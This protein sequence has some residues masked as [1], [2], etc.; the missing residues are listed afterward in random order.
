[1]TYVG[2]PSDLSRPPAAKPFGNAYGS[3]ARYQ[4]SGSVVRGTVLQAFQG[5]QIYDVATDFGRVQAFYLGA[6][7]GRLGANESAGF[8]PGSQ[9]WV[10]YSP[11]APVF[12]AVILGAATY[13]RAGDYKAP[14]PLLVYP[15]VSGF[16]PGTRSSGQ[17]FE[18]FRKLRN[19]NSG[20]LDTVNGDWIMHNT[21]GGALGVEI[22]R[23]FI[24]GGPMS[25][26]Y[27]YTEDNRTRIVGGTYE[28]MTFA[29][30][31]EDR[32]QGPGLVQLGRQV[33]YPM[34]AIYDNVPQRLQVAGPVYGGHQEFHSYR[35][36]NNATE[37]P[38]ADRISLLHEYRG[39]DGAYV[40]TSANSITLQRQVGVRVPLEII[41]P[42]GGDEVADPATCDT[43]CGLAADLPEKPLDS[44]ATN[45]AILQDMRLTMPDG[46]NPVAFA[47]NARGMADRLIHWQARGGFD[48]LTEQWTQGEKPEFVYQGK[49]NPDLTFTNSSGMWK[50]VPQ[51]FEVVVEPYG[52]TKNMYFGRS[53]ISITSDGSIVLQDAQGSQIMMSG[54]NIYLSAPHDVITV[55]GRNN[56]MMSG[57]DTAVRSSRHV[58]INAN[59][60][61]F[62]A[63]SSGQATLAGG[64]DGVSGV[65]IESFGQYNAAT[66]GEQPATAGGVNIR[67]NH[68]VGITAADIHLRAQGPQGWSSVSGG[69]GVISL[70]AGEQVN[71]RANNRAFYGCFGN[72]VSGKVAG[73]SFSIGQTAVFERL[74][75]TESLF[76]K[77]LYALADGAEVGYEYLLEDMLTPLG[78]Y[79]DNALESETSPLNMGGSFTIKW[80]SS[81]QYNLHSSVDFSIPEPE[82]QNRARDLNEGITTGDAPI[83][84]G[85][86][87]Q[88]QDLSGTAPLPGKTS[89]A[90]YGMASLPYDTPDYGDEGTE[91]TWTVSYLP[92]EGNLLKGI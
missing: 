15:Q 58:D 76:Y 6:S 70:D 91:L 53:I 56:L 68:Q 10:A 78:T 8:L 48:Q 87:F 73:G 80:L 12:N 43:G 5:L 51:M 69:A 57:R 60:G 11:A 28:L 2:L 75:T 25:G 14:S 83:I 82:W 27:C 46:V 20:I 1:M 71:W 62:Q 64:R 16:E 89:W 35:A 36:K 17:A 86:T 79:L 44:G 74:A 55:A 21:F 84:L 66:A 23:S 61:H 13:V 54:G 45:A 88:D 39:V 85:S 67:A 47:M 59:E 38:E 92:L 42:N 31:Y 65:H 34:D 63:V 19:Y 24:Q 40:L 90:G 18:D 81:A 30:E 9:V 7:R 41:V 4:A 52:K 49:D 77:R 29:E 72:T 33:Y 26:L 50:S 3:N 32:V 22:W 37:Q